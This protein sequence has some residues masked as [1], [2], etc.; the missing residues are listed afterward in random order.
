MIWESVV[1]SVSSA[2]QAHVAPMGFRE[3]DGRV[4][5]A[6]FHPSTTLENLLATRCAAVN[7][8]D[9]VRVFAG[10]LTGRHDWAT[11]PCEQIGCVRLEGALAHRELQLARVE[12][13]DQRPRLHLDVVLERTHAPFRGFNRAQAAVVEAAILVS[14][15]HLLPPAKIDSEMSYLAIAIE[16]TAGPRE[17]E[18][19]S[20]LIERIE[21]FRSGR[22]ESA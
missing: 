3:V 2:G 11:V 19:W 10:C 4:V 1:T 20:W 21:Q 13:D 15:L 22:R 16:K 9:D 14:R 17:R 12:Q 18:A 8:C 5:L 7:L 6:P